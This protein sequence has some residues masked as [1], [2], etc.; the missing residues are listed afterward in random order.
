MYVF[1]KTLVQPYI[2]FL[3]LLV[4][5][6]VLTARR[7]PVTWR[8][9]AVTWTGCLG[10]IVLSLP[11]VSRNLYMTLETAFPPI[12]SLPRQLDA[13]VVLGGGLMERDGLL[14]SGS[15]TSGTLR[16]CVSAAEVSR[17]YGPIPIVCCGGPTLRSTP[18]LS[19][20]GV[21]RDCLVTMQVPDT[22]LILESHSLNTHQNAKNT[23]ALLQRRGLENVALI[24]SASH[25]KRAVSCFNAQ[26][27][28]V[29]PL[30]C[31]HRA[32]SGVPPTGLD[33]IPSASALSRSNRAIQEWL[34]IVWYK[35]RGWI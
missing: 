34:G 20:A 11:I 24:T 21:M 6:L 28:T 7:K 9:V 29:V 30:P 31:S 2:G 22:Q 13:I 8:R 4:C 32:A 27:V 10:L 15:M 14:E 19:E 16:R 1:I 12:Q 25:M 23:A 33:W 3:L 5:G 18:Q 35:L 26:G 17:H